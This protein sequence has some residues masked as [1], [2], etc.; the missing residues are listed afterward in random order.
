MA[1]LAPHKQQLSAS[2]PSLL[3]KHCAELREWELRSQ[4]C[5]QSIG[6]HFHLNIDT[7]HYKNEQQE[8][9]L[10]VFFFFKLEGILVEQTGIL[11]VTFSGEI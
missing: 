4:H 8:Q 5:I 11:Q 1:T 2:L 3:Q 10:F 7:K 9:K 6:V